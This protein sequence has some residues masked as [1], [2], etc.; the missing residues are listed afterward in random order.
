MAENNNRIF[1]KIQ[2]W[3]F[4]FG[5]LATAVGILAAYYT[6][7]AG[8]KVDLA[9]KAEN[10]VVLELDK[11]LSQV[12]IILQENLITKREFF[13]F[14]EDLEKRLTRMELTLERR[15]NKK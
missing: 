8:I 6:T 7:I 9:G 14:K 11:K 4:L 3:Q 2:V 5:F 12:E 1:S 10:T 15:E 13:Q